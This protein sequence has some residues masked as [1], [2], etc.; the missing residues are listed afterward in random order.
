MAD[1][2][3]GNNSFH[4]LDRLVA[5]TVSGSALLGTLLDAICFCASLL[6]RYRMFSCFSIL[7]PSFLHSVAVFSIMHLPS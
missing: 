3:L 1:L 4:L 2:P 6:L 5:F 7:F